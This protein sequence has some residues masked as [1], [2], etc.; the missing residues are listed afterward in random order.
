MEK[1]VC[2]NNKSDYIMIPYLHFRSRWQAQLKNL[3]KIEAEFKATPLTQQYQP[4]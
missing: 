3:E 1:N 2:D 4:K